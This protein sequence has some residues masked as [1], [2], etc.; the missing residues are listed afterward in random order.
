M[1]IGLGGIARAIVSGSIAGDRPN[2]VTQRIRRLL[3][4][5]FGIETVLIAPVM[6]SDAYT[7][8]EAM[9]PRS[10]PA[11]WGSSSPPRSTPLATYDGGRVQLGQVWTFHRLAYSLG[12]HQLAAQ[13]G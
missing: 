4:G 5:R 1:A 6:V 2:S 10:D 11:T 3:E 9:R 8:R 12:L 13:P 7:G